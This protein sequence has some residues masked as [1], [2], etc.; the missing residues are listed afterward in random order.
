MDC[1]SEFQLMAI[2]DLQ[3]YP[4][5]KLCLI[6][7][8]LDINVFVSFNSLFAFAG[9]LGKWLA[10]FLLIRINGEIR[11]EL[12]TFRV[13]FFNRLW[14]QV[15]RCKS[16][17]VIFAWRVT[18]SWNYPNRPKK[19]VLLNYLTRLFLKYSIMRIFLQTVIV[20]ILNYSGPPTPTAE[21]WSILSESSKFVIS[22]IKD[23]KLKGG[24]FKE[25]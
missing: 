22:D 6:K 14:C 25:R 2:P 5:W 11:A 4:P 18:W 3:R 15:Y 23:G 21:V 20:I 16:G 24:F 9:S 19:Q 1:V 17:I 12:N 7:Y 8:E 10:H 13:R